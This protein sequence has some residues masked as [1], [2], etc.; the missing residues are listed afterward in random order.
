MT[1]F[2][3]DESDE[4]PHPVDNAVNF[5]ESMYFNVFDPVQKVGGWFRIG[6]RPNENYA[7]MSVCLF[8]PDGKVG[9]MY[10][11][12]EITKNDK[13]DAGGLR[14]T[15]DEPFKR[16]SQSYQGDVL[17]LKNPREMIDPKAAFQ[18]NPKEACSIELSY[19]GLSPLHGGEP[20]APDGQTM[21]GRSF[22]RGHFNQHTAGV[23]TI[24][25]G[26]TTYTIN[27]FGWRDH[28][29]GPRYWQNI[30]WYRLLLANFGDDMG[31][32][33]LKITDMDRTTRRVGVVFRNGR[34]EEL[35]DMDLM[36]EYSDDPYHQKIHLEARTTEGSFK[37]EGQVRTLLPLRNRRKIDD[38]ILHTRICEGMTEWTAEGRTGWGLCEYLDQI[39]D[40]QP[41]GFPH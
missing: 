12:P 16:F 3:L 17:I 8:L 39:V 31:F 29:W 40:D 6:N 14:F 32:M 22:S 21:Y 11:R 23:G 13:H 38:G 35:L 27:G 20:T 37:A 5:N 15:V 26:G 28:S 36:T 33:I 10:A 30:W 34:Y 41:V 18:N 1:D 19:T 24:T 9:F 25:V 2:R 4:F 7:E